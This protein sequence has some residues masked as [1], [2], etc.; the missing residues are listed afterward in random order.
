VT[1]RYQEGA[2]AGYRWYAKTGAKPLFSLGHGLSYT[3]F[4]YRDFTVS[5]GEAPTASFTVHNVGPR[6]GADVPQVYL[7]HVLTSLAT[8]R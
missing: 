8:P 6:A 7:S 2:E 1:V 3:T 4:S 5:A